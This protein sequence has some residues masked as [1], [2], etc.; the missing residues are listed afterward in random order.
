MSTEQNK[1]VVRSWYEA[2]LKGDLNA[3]AEAM[4]PDSLHYLPGMPPLDVQ[5]L[6]QMIGAFLAAFPNLH[7][8]IEDMLA[9]GDWVVLRSSWGG[10]HQ[11]DLM[12]IPPT[13]QTV[14]VGDLSFFHLQDG[15]I[16]EHWSNFDQL[17]M[18]QQLGVIPTPG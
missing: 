14:K 8:Q 2:S 15:K 1:T 7:G 18:M 5:A 17:G 4:T 6:D 10:T 11:G 9:E 13:G 16:T 12:G 3:F